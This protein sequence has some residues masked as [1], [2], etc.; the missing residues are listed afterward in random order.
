[1]GSDWKFNT[2]SNKMLIESSSYVSPMMEL[3]GE[4]PSTVYTIT[5]DSGGIA[6]N[7]FDIGIDNINRNTRLD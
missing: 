7:I 4:R 3:R 5:D 1:M 6:M 2:G